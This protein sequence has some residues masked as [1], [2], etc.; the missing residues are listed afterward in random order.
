[1]YL[2]S[3]DY[4]LGY[5][6]FRDFQPQRVLHQVNWVVS[7]I[8]LKSVGMEFL[9]MST[10]DTLDAETKQDEIKK[11]IKWCDEN[12]N[13]TQEEL[14]RGILETTTKWSE[15]NMAMSVSLEHKYGVIPILVK[16]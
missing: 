2:A 10:F 15:F 6:F 11:I 9:D 12:Q 5:S 14:T 3:S 1:P 13:K 16:R 7:N 4:I 8:I